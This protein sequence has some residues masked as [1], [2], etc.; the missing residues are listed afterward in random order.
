MHRYKCLHKIIICLFS[1][2]MTEFFF[3]SKFQ[4]ISSI[5]H[6]GA[7]LVITVLLLCRRAIELCPWS[8]FGKNVIGQENAFTLWNSY[9]KRIFQLLLHPSANTTESLFKEYMTENVFVNFLGR[10]FKVMKN[11]VYFIVL[12]FLVVRC[13]RFWFMQIRGL[14]MSQ[15]WHK[16]MWNNKI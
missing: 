12:T 9:W 8:F 7:L 6:V 3:N 11:V 2:F 5:L 15:C 13:S 16:M 4:A 14:V 10:A 1:L